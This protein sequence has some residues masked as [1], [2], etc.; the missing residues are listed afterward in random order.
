[1][2]IFDI[3]EDILKYFITS[4]DNFS[5]RVN[6]NTSTVTKSVYYENW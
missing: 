6:G 2:Y 1:M 3:G 5:I 4:C